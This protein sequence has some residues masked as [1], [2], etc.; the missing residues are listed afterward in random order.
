M[1]GERGERGRTGARGPQGADSQSNSVAVPIL[2]LVLAVAFIVSLVRTTTLATKNRKTT[3]ALSGQVRR[4]RATDTVAC[5]FIVADA[6]TRQQQAVNS[7]KA[8]KAQRAYTAT[9]R[10]LLKLFERPNPH[11][12]PTQRASGRILDD[13]LK[14]QITLST[15]TNTQTAKNIVLT[16]NL[17]TTAT[18]LAATLPCPAPAAR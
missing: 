14:S 1:A 15:A 7:S 3:S 4:L 6:S 2:L 11:A 13:Y 12:T 5:T 18:Q 8:L 16:Q 17:A 10:R 9:T